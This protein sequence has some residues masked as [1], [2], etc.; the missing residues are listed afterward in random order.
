MADFD[1]SGLL[2]A[3]L[4]A[5]ASLWSA[6]Q[7][8]NAAKKALQAQSAATGQAAG[9]YSPYAALGQQAAGLIN[10]EDITKLPG[11]QSGLDAALGA[12]DRRSAAMGGFNSG[13]R[14]KALQ[15]RAI[16]YNTEKTAQRQNQ[17]YGLINSGQNAA[18]AQAGLYAG[19][20]DASGASRIAQTNS[21]TSGLTG[22]LD[23]ASKYLTS[24]GS[25]GKTN[26]QNI[27]SSSGLSGLFGGGN[28]NSPSVAAFNDSYA[29]D[30]WS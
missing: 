18:G 19:L 20:G 29:G 9:V 6:N 13:N 21:A 3:G 7:N 22:A 24:K 5:G 23:L 27:W 16:D 17:L 26:G 14:L 8:A 25:N 15:Q 10:N 1:W 4:G 2:G 12:I 30:L 28:D 11:Y